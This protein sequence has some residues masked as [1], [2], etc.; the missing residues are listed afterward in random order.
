[1]EKDRKSIGLT[2]QTQKILADIE[3]QGWFRDAQD[4]ARFALAYAVKTNVPEG[5]TENTETR[6]AVG[7]FD[8]TGEIKTLLGAIYP[9]CE[10]PVK[11]MEHL[12]NEGLKLLARKLE[13]GTTNPADL[14]R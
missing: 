9:G 5:T 2:P 13:S 14:M 10:T 12:V 3:G 4:I 7:N 1:M 6:W 11:L 8:D